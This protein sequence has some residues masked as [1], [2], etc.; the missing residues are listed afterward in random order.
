MEGEVL[1]IFHQLTDQGWCCSQMVSKMKVENAVMCHLIYP[2]G[3]L[4]MPTT[5]VMPTPRQLVRTEKASG[6]KDETSSRNWNKSSC[7]RN[8]TLIY[9][10]L[11]ELCRP[12][13]FHTENISRI[14][15]GIHRSGIGPMRRIENGICINIIWS[16][17]IP[18]GQRLH[19]ANTLIIQEQCFNTYITLNFSTYL[20]SLSFETR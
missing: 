7:L 17:P 1:E 14:N 4:A 18:S 11:H 19:Y 2:G 15:K 10:E 20:S 9:H 8:S 5:L 3:E 16:I 6:M 12:S 13:I